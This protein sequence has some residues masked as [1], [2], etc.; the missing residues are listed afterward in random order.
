[1]RERAPAVHVRVRQSAVSAVL[2]K[3]PLEPELPEKRQSDVDNEDD[4]M[5][6]VLVIDDD[7]D[8]EREHG[9]EHEVDEP[10]AEQGLQV[11]WNLEP[12]ITLRPLRR[13]PGHH[14]DH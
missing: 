8:R 10:E 13:D 4:Q 1:M 6:D 14:D 2:I 9:E 7:M 5:A 3:I 12:C 11:E